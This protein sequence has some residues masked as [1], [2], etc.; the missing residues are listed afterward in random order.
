MTDSS[1]ASVPLATAG[2]RT[3]AA[4]PTV[5]GRARRLAKFLSNHILLFLVGLYYTILEGRGPDRF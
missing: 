3:D 2:S 5:G 4:R 1:W